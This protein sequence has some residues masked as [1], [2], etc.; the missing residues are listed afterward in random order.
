MGTN[1]ILAQIVGV[2]LTLV[3]L[4]GFVSG[5]SL[6]GFQVNTLHNIVH[7]VSGLLGLYAG[8]AAGGQN[9]KMFNKTL[10]IIYVVVA[11][12]G[13]ALPSTM[14]KLLAINMADNL[15]HLV[16]GAVLALVGY[17]VND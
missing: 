12:L 9:A 11:V 13:F 14:F 16:L 3:G 7:L 5:G 4:A 1:K 2:V 15:L 8:F 17:A 6:L 10:G